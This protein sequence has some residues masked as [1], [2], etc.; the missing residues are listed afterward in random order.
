MNPALYLS[1]K[2]KE[3][4]PKA[5]RNHIDTI[6]NCVQKYNHIM[7]GTNDERILRQTANI[8]F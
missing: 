4:N 1:N 6:I 7:V 5:M 2:K 8:S 3:E